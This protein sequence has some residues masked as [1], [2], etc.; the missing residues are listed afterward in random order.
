MKFSHMAFYQFR[1]QKI[2]ANAPFHQRAP[3][4]ATKTEHPTQGSYQNEALLLAS[5]GNGEV[6]PK[7][8]TMRRG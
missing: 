3:S 7:N 6:T 5:G 4:P 1:K 2:P 8:W